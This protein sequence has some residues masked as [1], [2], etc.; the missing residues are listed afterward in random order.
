MTNDPQ[1]QTFFFKMFNKQWKTIDKC[2]ST[3]SNAPYPPRSL[4]LFGK[5]SNNQLAFI[6]ALYL[7]GMYGLLTIVFVGFDFDFLGQ[8][9]K[10][11]GLLCHHRGNIVILRF[12]PQYK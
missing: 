4:L 12:R 11:V 7:L 10:Y 1:I 5:W 6:T 3:F 8:D 9:R 2:M